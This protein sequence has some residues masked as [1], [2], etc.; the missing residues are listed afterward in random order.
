MLGLVSAW[1]DDCRGSTP[2]QGI[3]FQSNH[4]DQLSLAIPPSVVGMSIYDGLQGRNGE[5][6]VTVGPVT[7]W[8]TGLVG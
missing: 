2:G 3:L 4:P 5:F 6:C 7:S 8:H 1:M